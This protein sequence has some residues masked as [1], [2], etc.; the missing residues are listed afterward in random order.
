VAALGYSRNDWPRLQQDLQAMARSDSATLGQ[1]SP[2]GQKYEVGATLNGPSGRQ[3][4]V[5]TVWIVLKDETYP[6]LV[7]AYPGETR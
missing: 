2:F 1:A 7:T 5:V 3:A 4:A 6:R